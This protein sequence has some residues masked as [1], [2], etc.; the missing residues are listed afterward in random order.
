TSSAASDVYKRQLLFPSAFKVDTF[1]S[2]KIE[3][4]EFRLRE[5]A[6]LI[7]V[8]LNRLYKI[9]KTNV[10]ICAVRRKDVLIIPDGNT[11]LEQGDRIHV[12]LLYTS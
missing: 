12:C 8:P 1:V 10:L 4:A 11:V 3:M 6:K 2:G 5:N 9:S 7:N